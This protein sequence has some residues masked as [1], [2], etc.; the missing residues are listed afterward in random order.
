MNKNG[1]L[2]LG[3][4]LNRR[5]PTEIENVAF[6][7]ISVGCGDTYSFIVTNDEIL[8]FGNDSPVR[9]SVDFSCVEGRIIQVSCRHKT[10]LFLS[11]AGKIYHFMI[12]KKKLYPSTR[13]ND[14]LVHVAC[15]EA[16]FIGA[17]KTGKVYTWG[18]N[19]NWGKLGHDTSESPL[20]TTLASV[21][22]IQVDAG[23][24]HSFALTRE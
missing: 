16:H 14:E 11:D 2:G 9:I 12:E 24:N 15:G 7:I 23:S 13:V 6:P 18:S 22:A 4:S 19:N 17:S 5:Q 8:L 3:H 20:V 21:F 1:Q 10:I